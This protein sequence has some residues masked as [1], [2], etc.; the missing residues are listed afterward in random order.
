[1]LEL[2]IGLTIVES[3]FDDFTYFI[4]L[5]AYALDLQLSKKWA[6]VTK[7]DILNQTNIVVL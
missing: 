1:M 5:V 7:C 4:P 2:R 3:R 6:D